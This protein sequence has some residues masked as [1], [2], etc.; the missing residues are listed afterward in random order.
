M[1]RVRCVIAVSS[2]AQVINLSWENGMQNL[3]ANGT[4]KAAMTR[5]WNSGK[6]VVYCAGNQSTNIAYDASTYTGAICVGGINKN[7]GF[8]S[9]A[10]Y[11]TRVDMA[12]A[13]ESITLGGNASTSPWAY[14]TML[15]SGTSFASP[16]VAGAVAIVRKYTTDK[17]QV[18]D[19]LIWSSDWTYGST[20]PMNS[21]Y[22]GTGST[23]NKT[24]VLN[25]KSAA[26]IASSYNA[27]FPVQIYRP[28]SVVY[29]QTKL[30]DNSW[31]NNDWFPTNLLS[32]FTAVGS[33]ECWDYN[34]TGGKWAGSYVK[35]RERRMSSAQVRGTP[36]LLDAQG[37]NRQAVQNELANAMD[38]GWV[39]SVTVSLP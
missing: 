38:Q 3:E 17:N 39:N 21:G 32:S 9:G 16:L 13:G 30:P 14:K 2:E 11:G 31:T 22:Q 27:S 18:R 8:Y 28:A 1:K 25:A 33:V 4:V 34:N 7:N 37:T 26:W 15:V 12:A 20:R 19:I 6:T 36:Y 29:T 35:F 5:A 24:R 10:N 23:L